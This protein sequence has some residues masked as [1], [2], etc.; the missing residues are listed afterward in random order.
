ML[1][2]RFKIASDRVKWSNYVHIH[3]SGTQSVNKTLFYAGIQ[4]LVLEY[5]VWAAPCPLKLLQISKLAKFSIGV[6][7]CKILF[8]NIRVSFQITEFEEICERKD[9]LTSLEAEVSK[10]K[11]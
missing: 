4:A 9:Q 2:S 11:T 5:Q 10:I 7:L 1:S 3:I 6:L 8:S